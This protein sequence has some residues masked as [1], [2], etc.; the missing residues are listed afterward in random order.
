MAWF[1]FIAAVVV[2]LVFGSL[3]NMLF[4]SLNGPLIP[5]P[6]GVDMT[7]PEGINAAMPLLQ[8][9]HFLMPFLAHAGGTLLAAFIAVKLCAG[10][11][12]AA[13]A[14]VGSLFLCGGLM[15][16]TLIPAPTWFIV[17]DLFAAYLPMAWLGY[18]LAVRTTEGLPG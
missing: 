12:K 9:I 14:L 16:A 6:E 5:L 11:K 7:T 15:A 17:V 10:Y 2:G 18:R 1:K 3:L 8:P 4:V 13:A